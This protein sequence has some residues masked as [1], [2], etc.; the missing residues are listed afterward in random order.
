MAVCPVWD[1]RTVP[2]NW[3]SIK[4]QN[5]L[6]LHDERLHKH[7]ISAIHLRFNGGGVMCNYGTLIGGALGNLY[8]G[9]LD[10]INA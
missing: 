6:W 9:R 7:H 10:L 4:G 3:T 1:H 5:H 8:L 2:N